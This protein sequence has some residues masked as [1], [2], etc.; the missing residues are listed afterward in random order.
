MLSSRLSLL[1]PTWLLSSQ[2]TMSPWG[3]VGDPPF[4]EPWP[5]LQWT[6]EGPPPSVR[7][8]AYSWEP[9]GRALSTAPIWGQAGPA[10]K[11]LWA[12]WSQLS[13]EGLP[14]GDRPQWVG[15]LCWLAPRTSGTGTAVKVGHIQRPIRGRGAPR[16]GGLG[17]S[18]VPCCQT[19]VDLQLLV[20]VPSS[21]PGRG[22]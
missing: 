11:G 14:M 13:L 10:A 5:P 1:G 7:A 20:T 21:P 3:R 15:G 16:V 8:Q 6:L 17:R 22:P 19:P 4:S 18:G 9:R 2:G 12:A